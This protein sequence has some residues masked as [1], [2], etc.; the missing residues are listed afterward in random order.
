MMPA[1]TPTSR[2]AENPFAMHRIERLPFRRPGWSPSELERRLAAAGGR[3]A[4]IGP[5][6]SGKTS[7][8]DEVASRVNGAAARVVVGGGSPASWREVRRQLPQ[9]IA[10]GHAVFVDGYEQLGGLC[11]R[12]LLRAVR[13]A[14]T[15][16]VTAHEPVGLPTVFWCHTDPALLRDLVNELAPADAPALE[17]SLDELF[18]RHRGNLRECFRELYDLYAGRASLGVRS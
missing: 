14:G 7:L 16:L 17:P 9:Q 1:N 4:V 10:A 12:R 11:R 13:T 18:H 8:L 2:P 5:K 6:G 15:L 3:G